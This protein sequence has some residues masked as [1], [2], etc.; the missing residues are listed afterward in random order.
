MRLAPF[1]WSGAGDR[2][3]AGLQSAL[4][5]T[6]GSILDVP[7][8]DGTLVSCALTNAAD[9]TVTHGLGRPMRGWI[10]VRS[11]AAAVLCDAPS[12]VTPPDPL[13]QMILRTN[14]SGSFSLWVF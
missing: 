11:S 9:N 14:V 8:L 5:A 10:V 3:L 4:S 6:L 7:I 2:V 13:R 1:R 12:T